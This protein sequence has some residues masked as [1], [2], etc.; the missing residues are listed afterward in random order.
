MIFAQWKP[1]DEIINKLIR[2]KKI[3]LIGC[4]TCVA[5][6]AA[7]GEKEVETLA[8]LLNMGLKKKGHSV[9]IITKTLEKQCE[10]EFIEELTE[11]VKEVDAI[12]S[13]SC[14][15]GVQA[16][17]ERFSEKPVYPGV[18]TSALT[19]RQEEG[20]WESRCVACG[21]C[22]LDETF[23]L[24]PMAR[25]AKNIMNGPCGGTRKNGKCEIDEETDCIWNL[26]IERAQARKALDSLKNI[27]KTKNWSNSRHGGPKKVIREDLRP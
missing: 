16:V 6:C 22:I 3:L 14:G 9:Q 26:I 18:N 8:P 17:A 13:L 7:G 4:A 12:L 25:C 1:I 19:I 11:T 15:I 20:Q 10:W 5:E 27:R 2:H 24:C 23:G 21:D